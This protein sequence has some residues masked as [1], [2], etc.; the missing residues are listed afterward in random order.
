MFPLLLAAIF[1]GTEA[2]EGIFLDMSRSENIQFTTQ[3]FKMMHR[4]RLLKIHQ[5]D[6]YNSI[7]KPW[8]VVD[9]SQVHLSEMHVTE[10]FECPFYELR[11]LHW[12]GYALQTLPLDFHARNLV[13]LS[14]RFSN[15][16]QL[17]KGKVSL[18]LYSYTFPFIS[19]K[20]MK[21]YF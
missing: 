15:I 19:L 20:F 6:T 2:I 13:E 5:D 17:W 12:D 1:Q 18:L 8:M 21:V 14:L 16:K 9:P 4:L 3:A 7:V 11:Y 10:D